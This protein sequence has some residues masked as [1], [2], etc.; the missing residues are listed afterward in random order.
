MN[1]ILTDPIGARVLF[2]SILAAAMMLALR[3]RDEALQK[4]AAWLLLDWVAA[5]IAYD[6][7]TPH[8]SPWATPTVSALICIPLGN[9]AIRFGSFAV[10]SIIGL[11]VAS[12]AVSVMAFL[13]QWQGNYGYFAALNV[14]FVLRAV[15]L[16]GSAFVV[17]MAHR[18]SERHSG[19]RVGARG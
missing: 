9:L 2:G 14:L 6:L 7:M 10:W 19:P 11:M 5:N 3:S 13:G 18:P 4:T 12:L 15:V 1:D 8:W 17:S 16:G